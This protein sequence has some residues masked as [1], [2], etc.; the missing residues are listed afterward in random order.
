MGHLI[1]KCGALMPCVAFAQ[2]RSPARQL[3]SMAM[4]FARQMHDVRIKQ[5]QPSDSL[6]DNSFWL[7]KV[8]EPYGTGMFYHQREVAAS[9]VVFKEPD[10]CY[11]CQKL[12]VCGAIM[13]VTR[14]ECF[15]SIGNHGFDYSPIFLFF[16]L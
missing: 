9:Q 3:I 6:C 14:T 8:M 5:L 12:L 4:M 13:L 7:L 16:L 11:N 10:G 15:G 2:M 1:Q